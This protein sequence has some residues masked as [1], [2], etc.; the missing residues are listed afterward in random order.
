MTYLSG[1]VGEVGPLPVERMNLPLETG[2]KLSRSPCLTFVKTGFET[3]YPSR[4]NGFTVS[5]E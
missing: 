1:G 2:K 4:G 3:L 5:K